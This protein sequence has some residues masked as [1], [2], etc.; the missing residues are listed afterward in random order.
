MEVMIALAL[1]GGL[2]LVIAQLGKNSGEISKRADTK[3]SKQMLTGQISS[4]L[5]D[6]NACSSTFSSTLSAANIVNPNLVGV[7]SG[8]GISLVSG[9]V[10]KKDGTIFLTKTGKFAEITLTDMRLRYV[11]VTNGLGELHITGTYKLSGKTVELKA[12][13]IPLS[14]NNVDAVNGWDAD[15]NCS[16]AGNYDNIW[17]NTADGLGI[18]YNSG[19]VGI[20]TATPQTLLQVSRVG[21]S[22]DYVSTSYT[23]LSGTTMN[24]RGTQQINYTPFDDATNS[25]YQAAIHVAPITNDVYG[26][27]TD[28]YIGISNTTYGGR[29]LESVVFLNNNTNW[30][31]YS[32]TYGAYGAATIGSAN[33]GGHVAIGTLGGASIATGVT[34]TSWNNDNYSVM[35]GVQGSISGVINGNPGTYGQVSA[36]YG[37]DLTS[38]TFGAGV[39]NTYAGYFAGNVF[40]SA[41][42]IEMKRLG[43]ATTAPQIKA[44]GFANDANGG[45]YVVL[46]KTRGTT[47]NTYATTLDGDALGVVDFVGT[48]TSGATSAATRTAARIITYQDGAS[49]ATYVPGRMTFW[50]SD[51]SADPLQR[52]EIDGTGA[53]SI[54]TT[55][56]SSALDVVALGGGSGGATITSTGGN[57]LAISS[58]G[59]NGINSISSS[60]GTGGYFASNSGTG[61]YFTSTSG[62]ALL[63]GTGNVGIGTG[64]PT[65]K[66]Y[67]AGSTTLAPGGFGIGLYLAND[68]MALFR[69]NAGVATGY[70]DLTNLQFRDSASTGNANIGIA[71]KLGIGN[72]AAAYPLDVTGDIRTSQCLRYNASTLG[73][74]AS[75]KRIK[76]DIHDFDLGLKELLGINPV[77]YK[78]NGLGGFPADKQEQIGVIAQDLEKTVPQLISKKKVKLHQEDSELTEIKVVNYSPFIYMAINS[79]KELYK[80]VVALFESD[81]EQNREIATIKAEN[82]RLKLEHEEMKK[83]LCEQNKK[84]H[85]C[86]K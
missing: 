48:N 63:T 20:G 19:L 78:H 30:A 60:S 45:A 61:G 54:G 25:R 68:S 86:K 37:V 7:T 43:S 23:N 81:K 53:V 46:G 28:S 13:N 57:G 1:A 84:A 29:S 72:W 69:A 22:G 50:T 34:N 41:G 67:V 76:K 42:S 18:Y 21:A 14:I 32:G 73:T 49:G 33:A 3:N 52:M 85:F 74:C 10:F 15:S 39:G 55:T 6:T 44:T 5:S 27:G 2:A 65:T 64:A 11:D 47:H 59:G 40:V 77:Y 4:I 51:G 16:S 58:V 62:Y 31:L 83:I 17:M 80:K 75:D 12:M 82:E 66:L 8:T 71:G 36:V 56:H 38:G 70:I 35:R 24:I 26:D 79:I 9:G